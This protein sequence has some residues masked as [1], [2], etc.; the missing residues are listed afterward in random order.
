M[1]ASAVLRWPLCFAEECWVAWRLA[2][3]SFEAAPIFIVGHWRSGTTFLHNLMSRDHA[4]CFPTIV[5]AL[6]PYDFYPGPFEFIT[7]KI[8]LLSLPSIRPMDDVPLRVDLPQE[9]EIALACMGAPSF[10]NCF[11]FPSMMTEIFA[12]E[13]LLDGVSAD[14]EKLWRTS[15]YY[16]LAKVAARSPGRRLLLKNPAHSARIAKL[17][18][19][20][21]DAKFIHIHR[22][23][24]EVVASTR[25]TYR[26][27]LPVLA[28]QRYDL[29][30]VDEH[31][32]WSYGRLMDRLSESL[33]KLPSGDFAQVRYADLAS[34]PIATV[35]QVYERLGLKGFQL[36]EVAISEFAHSYPHTARPPEISDQQFAARNADRLDRFRRLLGYGPSVGCH[37]A[38]LRLS[39]EAVHSGHR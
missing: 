1:F 16:Y 20:F 34:N 7:R 8:L 10:F 39:P 6:R 18:A 24:L 3:R 26:R 27:M 9:D 2:A 19:L 36:A 35:A 33:A 28:L 5:D 32:I 22:D 14:D 25:K 38:N 30:A 21:P 31:I 15:L 11:Y 13:V 12:A 4:F 17:R 37:A 23:P 29:A